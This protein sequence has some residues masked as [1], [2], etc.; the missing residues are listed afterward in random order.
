MNS[1]DQ[2]LKALAKTKSV[3]KGLAHFNNADHM[4]TCLNTGGVKLSENR[5]IRMVQPELNLLLA[6]DPYTCAKT[7][8][9]V[10]CRDESSQE[11]QWDFLTV[12][13]PHIQQFAEF[14]R[15]SNIAKETDHF[16]T[17]TANQRFL[18]L[19]FDHSQGGKTIPPETDGIDSQTVES[20]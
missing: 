12:V 15:C 16:F 14:A 9:I 5:H 19:I 2:I 20:Q 17:R 8:T 6:S 4:S 13:A 11:T 18:T 7:C 10:I 1:S 3:K